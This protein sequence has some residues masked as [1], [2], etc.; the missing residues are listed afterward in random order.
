MLREARPRFEAHVR[1]GEGHRSHA[2]EEH[3]V[4]VRQ[5]RPGP[6]DRSRIGRLGIEPGKPGDHRIRSAVADSCRPEGP[7][8]RARHTRDPVEKLALAQADGEVTPGA[9]RADGVGARGSYSDGEQLERRD[10]GAHRSRLRPTACSAPRQSDSPGSWSRG[11]R[12]RE[13]YCSTGV[14][15]SADAAE[16]DSCACSTECWASVATSILRGFAFSLT[17]IVTDSTPLP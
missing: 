9:H 2:A 5:V 11:C 6:A 16:W 7:V 15:P 8:E 3:P 17:G 4:P 1:L 12:R 10:I 13:V 14:G